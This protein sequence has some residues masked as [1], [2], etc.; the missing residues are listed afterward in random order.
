MG[1]SAV[2]GSG[3]GVSISAEGWLGWRFAVLPRG[4]ALWVVKGPSKSGIVGVRWRCLAGSR[5]HKLLH[6]HHMRISGSGEQPIFTDA[7]GRA[8]TANQPHAP[9][10][11]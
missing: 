11:E 3:R 8:I 7:D 4:R 9:P 6:D 5:H 2:R 10:T 1:C